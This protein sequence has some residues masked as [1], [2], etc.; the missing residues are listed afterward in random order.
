MICTLQSQ[1]TGH[2]RPRRYTSGH[3]VLEGSIQV[4]RTLHTPWKPIDRSADS[5]GL[6]A[7][8]RGQSQAQPEDEGQALEAP[9]HFAK[10]GGGALGE[11]KQIEHRLTDAELMPDN[12]ASSPIR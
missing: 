10:V 3:Q 2:Q 6:T 4:Q 11:L 5:R 12:K 8:I 7:H 9:R 1:L